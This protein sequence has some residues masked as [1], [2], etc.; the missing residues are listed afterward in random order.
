MHSYKGGTGK[1]LLSANLAATLAKQGKNVCLI[2]LDFRAPSLFSIFKAGGASTWFNDYLNNGCEINKILIDLS[3]SITGTGKFFV[4]LANP[5]TE[6]IRDMS[7]KD[8]KWE[9][10]ALGRLLALRKT[11]LEQ[12]S[13]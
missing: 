13:I 9:T 6:A 12:G 1:T 10:N 7:T 2:D 11:L 5:S 8:R 4:G 3:S